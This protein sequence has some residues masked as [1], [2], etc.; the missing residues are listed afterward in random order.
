MSRRSSHSLRRFS[1]RA[2]GQP[3]F[4]S[5]PHIVTRPEEIVRGITRDEFKARRR[6]LAEQFPNTALVFVSAAERRSSHDTSVKFR[7]DST[8]NYLF[9]FQEP[10]AVAMLKP[11]GEFFLFCH[12]SDPLK[13][14]WDGPRCGH[15]R[16]ADA[17]DAKDAF[18]VDEL[19]ESS[20]QKL[21]SSTEKAVL[22]NKDV[23]FKN[24]IDLDLLNT[25]ERFLCSRIVVEEAREVSSDPKGPAEP[26]TSFRKVLMASER[27]RLVKS[28]DEVKCIM[29]AGRMTA[30]TAL[31]M[32]SETFL[33]TFFASKQQSSRSETAV[34][35]RVEFD[36]SW[37][38]QGDGPFFNTIVASGH[39]AC[40][41]H[42]TSS[43]QKLEPQSFTLIDFGASLK[44][45]YGGDC[46]RT[47]QIGQ[48]AQSH[49]SLPLG[50]QI[51][52]EIV[53][54]VQKQII[55]SVREGVSL[56]ELQ[57]KTVD[58]FAR[59]FRETLRLGKDLND[60]DMVKLVRKY[61][62]H[63]VSHFLGLD[64]HDTPTIKRDTPLPSNSVI[65]VEPG[66]YFGLED[67]SIPPPL[68]GIGVR[69]EDSVLV[70]QASCTLLTR[71][72]EDGNLDFGTHPINFATSNQG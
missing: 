38:P 10:G 4:K 23:L 2:L 22:V 67:E 9:G 36:L 3:S 46:T 54:D 70:A 15:H 31:N 59:H 13:E 71:F 60:E 44:S 8:F 34:K 12:K 19:N 20:L 25:A 39:R 30:M 72:R 7:Q 16:A 24:H 37:H 68:R 55:L 47:L 48:E 14:M 17:F 40:T 50:H 33:N 26:I 35:A 66:L 5:H 51:V 58:A 29:E 57:K 6:R 53:Q 52:W 1:V 28:A 62:P 63:G 18:P 45:G 27:L 41:L 43:D 65:T 64:V 32:Q 42:Y 56:A 11:T 21:L 61:F 69:I 49:G